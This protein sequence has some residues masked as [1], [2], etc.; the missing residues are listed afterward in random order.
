MD[1]VNLEPLIQMPAD[2]IIADWNCPPA[3]QP[4]VRPEDS[5]SQ[6]GKK[7]SIHPHY[8][9]LENFRLD[10]G[11]RQSDLRLHNR[12]ERRRSAQHDQRQRQ[13]QQRREGLADPPSPTPSAASRANSDPGPPPTPAPS[14]PP[15][16]PVNTRRASKRP[17]GAV[18]P[19]ILYD[20]DR[21]LGRSAVNTRRDPTPTPSEGSPEPAA[22]PPAAAE[23]ASP[24]ELGDEPAGNDAPAEYNQEVLLINHMGSK[25]GNSKEKRVNRD[26]RVNQGQLP[27]PLQKKRVGWAVQHRGSPQT[28]TKSLPEK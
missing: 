15:S 5:V 11:V 14:P 8:L 23:Y 13:L 21:R 4:E 26:R 7:P 22:P 9:D 10:H 27:P 12:R 19:P 24:A 6:L 20:V 17:S 3:D 18:T 25:A 1:Q 16:P 28:P 2:E